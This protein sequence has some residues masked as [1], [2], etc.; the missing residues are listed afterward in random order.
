[1]KT[2]LRNL[3]SVLKRFKMATTLNILALSVAFAAFMVIMMQLDY[4][5]NFDRSYPHAESIFRVEPAFQDGTQ[6]IIN[7][8]LANL[9]IESSPHIVAATLINPWGGDFFFNIEREGTKHNFQEKIISVYPDFIN[10]FSVEM[11]EGSGDVLK[12]PEKAI[13]PLSMARKLFG[14]EPATGKLLEGRDATYTVGGVY[15]DFPRNSAMENAIYRL[16]PHDENIQSWGNWNYSFY[17]RVDDPANAGDLF[18]NFKR[19]TDTSIFGNDFSWDNAYSLRLTPIP[20]IH[21]VTDVTYDSTPKASRQ[22]LM[23]L[24]AIAIVIV[25]IAG[26]NFTNFS[27]ALTPMRIKSINTQ[28]VLGEEESVIRRS[29]IMEAIM[30]GLLS[31]LIGLILFAIL[32]Y[33]PIASMTDA[34]LSFKAHP[35]IIGGTALIALLTGLLAGIY[36]SL[37]ITSFPPA[38]VLKGSFGLSPKGRKLRSILVGMQFIASFALIIGSL[39]MYLQNYYMQNSSLGY[40]KDQIIV[41][42]VNNNINKSRE[43]FT[44]QLKSFSGIE[45]VTYAQTLLSSGD[46]YM[47]WGRDFKNEQINFQCLPVDYTFLEVMNIEIAEGRNFR[48]EDGRTRHG[49]FIFNEK[50]RTMYNMALNEMVDSTSIVGFIPDVK[51]ASFRTEIAPMAFLVWGT[52][53]WGSDPRF[54]YIKVNAG[55]DMRAALNHVRTSLQMFDS[56]YPFNIRFFDEVLHRLYTKEQKLS[57]QITL[58]SI[59]AIFISIVGVFGLVV[60][61]SEY[62]RKEIGVRKVMGSTTGQILI[63]FNKTYMITLLICFVIAAPVAAYTVYQWLQNFAYKTPMYL[64]VF[65]VAFILVAIITACTVSF[66][67]WRAADSNP[68]DSIKTE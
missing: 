52:Q 7:R 17:I 11:A 12:E 10:V 59:I 8:P 66:Q 38:L 20:E 6:A 40:E 65:F 46:Q 36:P 25:I 58:F 53:T 60:F 28:K 30:V 24:F 49:A 29:I 44:N 35:V 19:I 61:D 42:N 3:F 55:S 5:R 26:I 34:D 22:T 68:V 56:E 32:P 13:I 27:T 50:A 62:R 16:M 63:M 1:M 18:E 45:D 43:A 67:N 48:E 31:Y 21:F 33:T 41:T 54:S 4:D 47:G 57:S 23:V 2:L 39:F 64:W 15:R 9:F 51:F 14:N 37:Y